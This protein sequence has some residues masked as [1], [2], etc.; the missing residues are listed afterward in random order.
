MS[1]YNPDH[2]GMAEFL[3]SG[4]MQRMVGEVADKIRDRAMAMAPVGNPID[5]EHPGRYKASFH[6]LVH[7]RGGATGDRAEAIVYNDSPEAI[8]VEFGHQGREPYHILL[9]AAT[10]A[11]WL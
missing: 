2:T 5:D 8:W 10:E 9:R 4:M 7:A 11:V 3:Q 1:D 6:V